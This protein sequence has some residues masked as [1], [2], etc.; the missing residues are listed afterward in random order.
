[1]RSRHLL[2]V[3]LLALASAHCGGSSTT[4]G[5][6]GQ[7]AGAAG[8]PG[9]GGVGGGAAGGDAGG[10]AGTSAAGAA[11]TTS[12]G[13]G[14]SVGG[15]GGGAAGAANGDGTAMHVAC[16]KS[17]G[18]ALSQAHGRLDGYLVAIVPSTQHTCNG[19]DHHV[20]LQVM[21]GG[22]VYDVAVNILSDKATGTAG[23][24]SFDELD[25]PLAGGAWQEGWHSPVALDYVATLGLHA[26][27]FTSKTPAELDTLLLQE[28]APA[29]HIS[30]YGTGYGPTGMHLIHRK[31][32]GEDG[33][34]VI[35]PTT[36]T[37]HYF[38]FHFATQ[39]F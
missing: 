15:A 19:D 22:A 5:G 11:G 33:A 28:L 23:D 12:A 35:R 18:S 24:V 1:M 36:G 16:T 39:S 31:Y 38:V 2:F 26:S 3:G 32:P 27:S 10:A 37:P 14:D 9:T 34:V 25:A 4:E 20:H 30:V 7:S 8:A 29:N 13:G 17:F 6:T 21:A